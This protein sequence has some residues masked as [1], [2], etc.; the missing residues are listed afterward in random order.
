M[1]NDIVEQHINAEQA[2]LLQSLQ[3]CLELRDKYMLMSR[4]RLGDDPRDRDAHFQPFEDHCVDVSGVRPDVPPAFAGDTGGSQG[5]D[6]KHWNIYP[7][8]PPPHWH[9]KENEA[10]NADGTKTPGHSAFR[11]EDCKIPGPH[12]GWS[13]SIDM[14]GIFQ[15]YD[16]TTGKCFPLV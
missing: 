10:I 4:Q 16:E 7:K 6:L 9:W 11:F 8:P 1:V 2:N 13:Y 12:D 15:V 14:T 5:E 3:K